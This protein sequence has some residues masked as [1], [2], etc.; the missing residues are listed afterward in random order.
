VK[1]PV[2]QVMSPT[3]SGNTSMCVL[4]EK[5]KSMWKPED[6]EIGPNDHKERTRVRLGLTLDGEKL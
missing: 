6:P 1:P 5:N 4:A 3:C 2:L